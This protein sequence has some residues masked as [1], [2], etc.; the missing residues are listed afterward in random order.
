MYNRK[1]NVGHKWFAAPNPPTGAVVNYYL[2]AKPGGPVRVTVT[3]STGKLVRELTGGGEP[4]LNRV[5]WDLRYGAP[6]GGGFGGRGGGGRGGGG[7]GGGRAGQ[8]QPEQEPGQTQ[9]PQAA[10][11]LGG[12]GG[13]FGGGRGPGVPPGDYT[14]K[15]SVGG[16]DHT[17]IV[18]VGEDPRV[19]ISDAD[20][21]RYNETL[22][23]AW[24][25]QRY[26]QSAGRAVQALKTQMTTIQ[27]SSRRNSNTSKEINDAIKSVA[28]QV[29]DL[30]GKIVTV[31]D[32]SG[33]AGPPLPDAPRPITGRIGQLFGSLDNYT[34]APTADQLT[35]LNDLSLELKGLVDQLNKLIDEGIPNLN[36]Q[37]RDS[38]VTFVNPGRRVTP[39][40]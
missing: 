36:K 30:Q 29:D 26:A 22:M 13:P 8:P 16:K 18:R 35:R 37:M 7:G 19:Q 33:N 4:G 27:E 14:I 11:Q 25:L 10:P 3:D 28:D 1:G 38:G 17:Q 24:E 2:K 40:Q 23:K 15:L 31:F 21:A 20:R 34:A 5:V 9:E 32:Q 12:G 6:G 39:P